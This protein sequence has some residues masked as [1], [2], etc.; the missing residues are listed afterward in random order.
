MVTKVVWEGRKSFRN[1]LDHSE[2]T[3]VEFYGEELGFWL[4][5]RG[6]AYYRIIRNEDYEI[7]VHRVEWNEGGEEA[8][9]SIFVYDNIDVAEEE[10]PQLL[11]NA[12]VILRQ[13]VRLDVWRKLEE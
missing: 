9:G 10:I 6:R 8:T 4:D 5:F 3:V 12:D 2:C 1:G 11:A 13:A 7:V